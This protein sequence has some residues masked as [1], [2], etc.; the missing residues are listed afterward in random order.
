VDHVYIVQRIPDGPRIAHF[1]HT[2]FHS[3]LEGFC[4]LATTLQHLRKLVD[5]LY[6][7]VIQPVISSPTTSAF[8]EAL[9]AQLGFFDTWCASQEHGIVMGTAGVGAP[10]CVSLLSLKRSLRDA[11]SRSFDAILDVARKVMRDMSSLQERD[12]EV[13]MLAESSA[14]SLPSTITLDALLQTAQQTIGDSITYEVLMHIFVASAEPM[15]K[16][17]G[18]WLRD[19]M[20]IHDASE[21]RTAAVRSTLDEEFFVKDNELLVLDPDYWS[22]GFVLRT[23]DLGNDELS[24]IPRFLHLVAPLILAAGKAVGLLRIL[25]TSIERHDPWPTFSSIIDPSTRMHSVDDVSRLVFDGIVSRCYSPQVRLLEVFFDECRFWHHL[26]ALEDVCLWRRGDIMSTLAD[27]IF[28]KV[29]ITP[30]K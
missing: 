29:S 10:R 13:W 3:I 20:A 17:T 23:A 21:E 15:W 27:D 26:S 12:A 9:S 24:P 4:E 2:S 18:R 5:K 11:F 30:R 28:S 25:S 8:A 6:A 14:F 19:G 7:A 16:V 22:E 1:T